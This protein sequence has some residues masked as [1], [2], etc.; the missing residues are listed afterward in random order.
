MLAALSQWVHT[1]TFVQR[2]EPV[3][4]RGLLNPPL[5]Q[6]LSRSRRAVRSQAGLQHPPQTSG[7]ASFPEPLSS[8]FVPPPQ[9]MAGAG[10]EP[11]GP[12]R[13]HALNGF[14]RKWLSK[15]LILM[16]TGP[17]WQVATAAGGGRGGAVPPGSLH[18]GHCWRLAPW[19]GI[20]STWMEVAQLS[21][22]QSG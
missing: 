6:T 4:D 13:I 10:E 9:S 15:S 16:K 2:R 17:Q 20:P 3:G 7:R 14:P 21:P 22:S 12:G 18:F 19:W 1:C 11:C 8:A 5:P